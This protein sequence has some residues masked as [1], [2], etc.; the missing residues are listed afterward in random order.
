MYNK[1][2]VPDKIMLLSRIRRLNPFG[3]II[4]PA[5]IS[6]RIWGILS[7]FKRIGAASIMIS[8]TRNFSTG[9]SRGSVKF[10]MFSRIIPLSYLF[11][12]SS[13]IGVMSGIE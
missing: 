11:C 4:A 7:L 3:P 5:M 10:N 12:K 9:F 6:P 13:Q 1:P 8:I 2:A